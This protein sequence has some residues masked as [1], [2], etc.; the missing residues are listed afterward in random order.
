MSEK[1]DVIQ[2][3][4]DKIKGNLKD[5]IHPGQVSKKYKSPFKFIAIIEIHAHR[6]IELGTSSL[7]LLKRNQIIAALIL[8]RIKKEKVKTLPQRASRMD[9]V[10]QRAESHSR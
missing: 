4:L 8:N 7:D 9:G 1:F 10:L 3:E 2:E 6:L 5:R